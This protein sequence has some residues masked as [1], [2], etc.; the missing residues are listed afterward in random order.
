[1]KRINGHDAFDEALI[2]E[3]K[4]DNKVVYFGEDVT[5]Y[6]YHPKV[7]E[8]V[9]K[10]NC[11]DTPIA[12]QLLANS[13]IGMALGGMRPVADIMFEDFFSLA[14]DGI[15]N[16]AAKIHFWS[17][18]TVSCPVVYCGSSGVLAGMGNNH[19]QCTA[20]W[21]AN[22]PGVKIALPSTPADTKG[23]LKQAIRDDDPVIFFRHPLLDWIEGEVPEG[24]YTTPFG[25]A[26]IVQ[27][28]SDV[29]VVCWQLTYK[30]MME[31]KEELA[32]DGISVEIIDPRTI[33]PLDKE[34]IIKSVNKTGRL[35][36]AHE[37]P[38]KYGPGAEILSTVVENCLPNLKAAPIRACT[39]MTAIPTLKLEWD[40]V[41]TKQ[42][43]KGA[44]YKVM[45]LEPKPVTGGSMEMAFDEN[46]KAPTA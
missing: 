27:E 40:V 23:L 10:S 29:T 2:E 11:F 24:D 1:M 44:I 35:V 15:V 38:Y 36:V 17:G 43:I 21:F 19:T 6:M 9:G 45:G 8:A 32:E 28:G 18:G 12:E 26:N 5:S 30:Y 41:V 22:V 39:P 37:E 20:A 33:C 42:Q 31:L 4:R 13:A 34:A 16:Q 7:A 14:F 46:A 3:I 25:K